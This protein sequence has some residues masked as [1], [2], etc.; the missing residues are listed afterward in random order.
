MYVEECVEGEDKGKR[1]AV[2]VVKKT[3]GD[4]KREIEAAMLFSHS[5]VNKLVASLR[6]CCT[7]C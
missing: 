1:R 5:K 7:H 6:K 2:K 3:K 4:F